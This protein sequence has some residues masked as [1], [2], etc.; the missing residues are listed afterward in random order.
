MIYSQ[1]PTHNGLVHVSI[2]KD[3]DGAMLTFIDTQ[4]SVM[5]SV[6]PFKLQSLHLL[7]CPLCMHPR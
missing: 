6:P 7:R 5:L 1:T 4:W 3:G 2:K